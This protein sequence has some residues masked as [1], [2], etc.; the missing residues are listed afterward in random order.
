[1][2]RTRRKAGHTLPAESKPLIFEPVPA[3][4]VRVEASEV[5]ISIILLRGRDL[6]KVFSGRVL[7]GSDDFTPF[8][9]GDHETVRLRFRPGEAGE[10]RHKRF[11]PGA[12][13]EPVHHVVA[14][15]KKSQPES[16]SFDHI[17]LLD[18]FY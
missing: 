9:Q 8:V 14:H 11:Q 6:V 4:P 5:E 15:G 12:W 18:Q 3:D 7:K 10:L 2:L 17:R 16:S 13:V 1:M